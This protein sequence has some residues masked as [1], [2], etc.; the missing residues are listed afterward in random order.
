MFGDL[1]AVSKDI[2]L[3]NDPSEVLAGE[4]LEFSSTRGATGSLVYL[5]TLPPTLL[6]E[7]DSKG[8]ASRIDRGNGVWAIQVNPD[9]MSPVADHLLLSVVEPVTPDA[10]RGVAEI[11]VSS[12][13][14]AREN[15]PRRLR[16]SPT[17]FQSLQ[18]R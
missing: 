17:L 1:G 15:P 2:F 4:P 8:T 18:D 16:L 12:V 9:E 7:D 5:K 3:S 6:I 11:A 13:L 10:A 14:E